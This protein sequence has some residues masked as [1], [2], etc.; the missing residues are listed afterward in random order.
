MTKGQYTRLLKDEHIRLSMLGGMSEREAKAAA[1]PAATIDDLKQRN[2]QL[3]RT[4]RERGVDPRTAEQRG[5]DD[6]ETATLLD[7]VERLA[8]AGGHDGASKRM[9]ASRL[10]VPELRRLVI[11]T[12]RYQQRQAGLAE[13][14]RQDAVTQEAFRR[15]QATM[16]ATGS[17]VDLIMTL[18][19]AR[20]RSGEGGGFF[21]GPTDRVGVARLSRADASAYI[22]SLR[23]SY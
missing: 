9:A 16:P 20:R 21:V 4:L 10:T 5:A 11:D 1:R 18:L 23:G 22:D 2:S 19:A 6:A 14:R 3:R 12:R 17:Q 15:R 7:E 13:A 8:T